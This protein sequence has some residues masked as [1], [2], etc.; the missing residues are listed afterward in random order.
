MEFIAHEELAHTLFSALHEK[1]AHPDFMPCNLDMVLIADK[2]V[3]R[4]MA[5]NT[6]KGIR[7]DGMYR[8]LEEALRNALK[9]DRVLSLLRPMPKAWTSH[10]RTRGEEST[11]APSDELTRAKRSCSE[12]QSQRDKALKELSQA[13]SSEKGKGKG[14]SSKKKKT[15]TAAAKGESK[16]NKTPKAKTK[17]KGNKKART[18]VEY[19]GPVP[20]SLPDGV[21]EKIHLF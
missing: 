16:G 2:E 11:S 7:P 20:T 18:D 8:P 12:M 21:S 14:R 19:K 9:N 13:E 17:A 10:T 3:W 6:K 15:Q 1:P 5:K 4:L